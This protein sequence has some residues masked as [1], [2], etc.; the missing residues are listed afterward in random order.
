[1]LFAR[2]DARDGFTPR[3]NSN[4][5]LENTHSLEKIARHGRCFIA[6]GFEGRAAVFLY[7][8]KRIGMTIIVVFI[9]MSFLILVPR[10]VPGDPVRVL[11]GSRWTQEASDLV[12]TEMGL[13]KPIPI[14]IV[15]FFVNALKGDLGKDFV[16]HLPV[17][18]YIG[19]A[20]P[21]TFILSVSG[22]T[23]AV[24][25]GIPLGII[26][27]TTP[28]G[29][30][31]RVTNILSVSFITI[32][33][34]V[35]GLFLLL[36]FA[37]QLG[38]LP[39]IGAG[40]LSD[41][42]DYFLHLILPMTSLALGW[43]GYLARLV[44]AS[45]LEVLNADFIT[46]ARSFGLRKRTIYY[47]HALKNALIPTVAILGVGLGRLLGGSIFAEVIF[48]RPG[49]GFLIYN[50]ILERN[51][52]IARGGILIVAVIFVLANLIADLSYFFL[53]PRLEVDKGQI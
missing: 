25:I 45:M 7:I 23:L 44:R 16:S 21:H 32:P 50:S 49:V 33:E 41:P 28:H 3:L 48:S 30:F 52:P 18:F 46:T 14:Q 6:R 19:A 24:L 34:Y 2:G 38:L 40:D 22:L 37:V 51:F 39:S 9:V 8:L 11:L 17:T 29:W 35:L 15:D 47:K 42:W 26:S 43:I 36:V 12:R 4:W 5:S 10:I 20:I 53:D 13:D 1:M 27:A 31:D